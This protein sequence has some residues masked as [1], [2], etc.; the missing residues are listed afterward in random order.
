MFEILQP[1]VYEIMIKV[2]LEIRKEEALPLVTSHV[3]NGSNN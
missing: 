3:W 2:G 1:K